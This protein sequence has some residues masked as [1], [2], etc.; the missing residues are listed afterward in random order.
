MVPGGVVSMPDANELL[1]CSHLLTKY[2]QWYEKCILGCTLERWEE[3]KSAADLDVWLDESDAHQQGDLGFFIRFARSIGLDKQGHGHGNF[4]SYGFLGISKTTNVGQNIQSGFAIGT[5]IQSLDQ[6]KITEDVTYSWYENGSNG[7]QHPFDG[8]TQPS[9]SA[10]T[11][12]EGEK[13]TWAKAARYDGL[14]AE[15]GPLAEMIISHNPLFT[16]LVNRNGSNAFVRQLARLVRTTTLLPTMAVYLK[17]MIAT[18]A[19]FYQKV[20]EI[21]SGEGFGLV[22]ATRGA[23][24]HW[25]KI[26]DGKISHY[27]IIT[28]TNWNGSPRDSAGV[29]G[30]WEEAIIGVEV[31]DVDNPVELGHVIRSF[32][33]CLVCTV[34]AIKVNR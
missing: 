32:D 26:E 9:I 8:K 15:T 10:R 21:E 1:Q 18:K 20:G 30:P 28:P 14:P 5:Q 22:E 27:Q 2:R 24:G 19:N 17:N 31:R 33:P 25:V 12:T 4:I 13:Y 11:Q 6:T 29:R 34:H 7:K 3:I 23:L 16:D